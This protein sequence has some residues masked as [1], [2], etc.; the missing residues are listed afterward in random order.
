MTMATVDQKPV[1]E[2]L[3]ASK[4]NCRKAINYAH[5]T[6]FLLGDGT[7]RRRMEFV[8]EFLERAEKKLPKEESYKKDKKRKKKKK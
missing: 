7:T 3:N 5:E 8:V 1:E 6:L 2:K 4:E